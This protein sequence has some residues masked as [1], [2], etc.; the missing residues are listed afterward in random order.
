MLILISSTL[1]SPPASQRAGERGATHRERFIGSPR[2][3]WRFIMKVG[4]RWLS[5]L[6]A[7]TFCNV[8]CIQTRPSVRKA[9][10]SNIE[11][12]RSAQQRK[13]DY[14]KMPASQRSKQGSWTGDILDV[15]QQC[16]KSSP[17]HEHRF[18]SCS[19]LLCEQEQSFICRLW[20]CQVAQ[21]SLL[22][23]IEHQ[24]SVP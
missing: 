22:V 14:R 1:S 20:E 23:L 5:R 9:T 10:P 17:A 7:Q 4:H 15:P 12:L 19:N 18:G 6:F 16:I 2:L 8:V 11:P 3:S 24:N 13:L 21:M